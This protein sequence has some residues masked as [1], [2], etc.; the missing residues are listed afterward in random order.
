MTTPEE[1]EFHPGSILTDGECPECAAA[2]DRSR[3]A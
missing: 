3:Q 2:F 1:C